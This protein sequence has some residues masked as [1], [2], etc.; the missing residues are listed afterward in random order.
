M[1]LKYTDAP[2]TI[3]KKLKNSKHYW[4]DKLY[5]L[6]CKMSQSE[7]FYSKFRGP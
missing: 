6:W 2:R 3:R 7:I 4:N 1:Y 5:D